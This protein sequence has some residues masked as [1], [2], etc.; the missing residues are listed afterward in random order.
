M[1][2]YGSYLT[3]SRHGTVFYFRRR[4]PLDLR[5]HLKHDA[6]CFSLRTG[7]RRI[8]VAR[9]RA[10]AVQTDRLFLSLRE[11]VKKNPK[12]EATVS[13]GW[14]LRLAK[15][16]PQTDTVLVPDAWDT[17]QTLLAG[18]AAKAAADA[19]LRGPFGNASP[20]IAGA[21][22]T[23]AQM[24]EEFLGTL[25]SSKTVR[26][27]RTAYEHHFFPHFGR[28]KDVH[29]VNQD[30]FA[31]WVKKVFADSERSHAT[32]EGFVNAVTSM[33][34]WYRA[35]HSSTPLISSKKLIPP[36]EQSDADQRDAFTLA[37]VGALFENAAHYRP[38]EPHK[39]WVTVC[40]AFMGCRIEE[41]AQVNLETD[42]HHDAEG[43]FWYLLVNADT[44][45][46]GVKRKGLKKTASKRAVPIHSALVK[47]GFVEYLNAQLAAG[48]TRPFERHW[49]CWVE[50]DRGEHLYSHYI[51][52][53]GSAELRRLKKAGKVREARTV[54]FH[55][56]RHTQTTYLSKR[57]V[58]EEHRAA[59]LGQVPGNAGENGGRYLTLRS[60]ARFLSGLVEQH[61]GDYVELLKQAVEPPATQGSAPP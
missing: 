11:E 31:E 25:K 24:A 4:I 7:D 27:Y 23:L 59:L 36:K 50:S 48:A 22:V 41:L 49:K 45:P 10:A 19:V 60:D 55:S 61:F 57:G 32:K 39:F 47:Y 28:E 6:L 8:A 52:R 12:S 9:A 40:V 38:A 46:D 21:A 43:G 20:P 14:S 58:V 51:S 3:R 1:A 42:L 35:S 17:P 53:W 29:S 2:R 44:D 13:V 37:E 26:A 34:S 30:R 33:F 54:Y 5:P 16:G 56:H 18:A 15:D